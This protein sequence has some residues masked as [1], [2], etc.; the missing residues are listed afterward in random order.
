[1]AH[2]VMGSASSDWPGLPFQNDAHR[3]DG[4]V[5]EKRFVQRHAVAIYFVLVFL[6]SWLGV[7]LVTGTRYLQGEGPDLAAV[8]FMAIPMLGAPFGIG[9]L[10]SYLVDGR[11]GLK[12]LFSRMRKWKV[13]AWWYLAL[14]IF[15]ILLACVMLLLSVVVS[16]EMVTPF[17]FPFIFIGLFAGFFEEI[18]WT[19]FAFPKMLLKQS[20]LA[21]AL[22]LG[23]IHGVWHFWSDFL[24][25]FGAMGGYYWLLFNAGFF[26]HV[27]ALRIL[28]SWV[29]TNTGSLFL[30]ILMHGSSSGFYGFFTA[31]LADPELRAIFYLVYGAVLWVPAL[32]VILKYGKTLRS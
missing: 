28:I 29:Y 8:G 27:V 13:R 2:S 18:G 32:V 4:S 30:A 14:A 3:G 9:I 15:P 16:R 20:A 7:Y 1:M 12:D 17:V 23:I 5:K 19:G 6:I 10:M 26:M 31:N 11:T 22:T 24:A 25:N 21:A